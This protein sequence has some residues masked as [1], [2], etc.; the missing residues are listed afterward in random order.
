MYDK[1]YTERKILTGVLIGGSAAGAYYFWRTFRALGKP[2][3]AVAA[4]SIAAVVMLVT[5]GS[6]FIP[7]LDRVPSSVFHIIQTGLALGAIRGFLSTGIAGHIDENRTVY[8]WG[9]T[10]LVAVISMT[11][12]MGAVVA[13]LLVAP[14]SFDGR[15]V[16][17]YGTLK[18]EIEFEPANVTEP[19]AG[20]IAAALTSVGFFDQ[21]A[22]K[23][24]DLAKSGDRFIITVYCNDEARTPEII[25]QFKELRSELQRSFP[26]NPIVI[27]MVVGTPDDRIARLE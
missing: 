17:H 14:D 9:N 20:R 7:A 23:T 3:H 1:I 19:E 26:A 2:G 16:R 5:L 10:I 18:H 11:I 27:D 6:L 15:T 25:E 22:K 24:V 13:V 8:G 4:V 12:T 21:E